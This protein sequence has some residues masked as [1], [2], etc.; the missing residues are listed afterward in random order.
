M[1]QREKR[2]RIDVHADDYA[3]SIHVS[4]EIIQCI[5]DGKID[6]ISV[7]PNMSC[8]EQALDMLKKEIPFEKMPKYSVH[9]NLMEGHC[10]S[11]PTDV[12]D[13]VDDRGYFKVSWGSLVIDSFCYGRKRNAVR[14]QIKIEMRRQIERVESALHPEWPVR[15]DSHQ[16]THMI[17]VVFDALMDA[18]REGNYK[19]E[20][21]RVPEEPQWP[22]AKAV[23]LWT[24][25]SP[26]NAV[27]NVVLN[28]FAKRNRRVIRAMGLP[29]DLLWGLMFS[30]KMDRPRVEKLWPDM[31]RYI[32]RRDRTLEIL[33]HPGRA[34]PEEI[35]EEYVKD[36]FVR[37]HLSEGR[38]IEKEAVYWITEEHGVH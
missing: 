16:H 32:E 29:Y 23:S 21:I 12:P 31:M 4:Q 22:F 15:I 6:S 1:R 11:D 18:V 5:K 37:F 35:G 26:I 25:Y 30:G 13:L 2:R 3:L 14:E 19:L 24:T 34:L 38:D 20:Y 10:L 17:P 8:F 33:F 27:K 9:L 7:M 28:A 36:G